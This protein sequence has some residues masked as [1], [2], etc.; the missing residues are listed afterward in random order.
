MG[1]V[2]PLCIL[3][4]VFMYMAFYLP[5]SRAAVFETHFDL[6]L[7]INIPAI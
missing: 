2:E 7:Q 1:T 6:V 4:L 3:L 5:V